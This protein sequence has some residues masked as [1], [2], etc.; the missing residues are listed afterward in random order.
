MD[1]Q[2]Q[3]YLRVAASRGRETERIGPFHATF[4]LSNDNPYLN[5]AIPDDHADPSPQDITALIAAYERRWR[6]PRL[7]YVAT[8]APAVEA[9]LVSAGFKV[10]YRTPLMMCA[11]GAEQHPQTPPGIE[12]IT[13]TTDDEISGLISAQNEAYGEAP[14]T[15][16]PEAVA[17]LR[18]NMQQGQLAAYARDA[19]SGE[20]AG[21][22]IATI[23][24]GGLTEIAGIGVRETFRRRSIAAALTAHLLRE[25]FALGV[26]LPFLMAEGEAEARIYTRVGFTRIGEI[27]HISYPGKSL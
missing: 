7:E 13:P 1:A 10:E 15:P 3:S 27:L 8:L 2:I 12:I 5:Y 9:A 23:P 20:P 21:G 25:A 16:T 26:T 17:H 19:T 14:G 11:P 22:G 6:K 4:D 18:S 24:V